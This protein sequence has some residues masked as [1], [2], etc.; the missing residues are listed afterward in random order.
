MVVDT[1]T[2]FRNPWNSQGETTTQHR[3]GIRLMFELT[4]WFEYLSF[5]DD[6]NEAERRNGGILGE[7]SIDCKPIY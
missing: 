7:I 6:D 1:M 5:L 3:L 4:L 2:E